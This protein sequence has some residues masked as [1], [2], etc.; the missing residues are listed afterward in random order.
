MESKRIEIAPYA[1]YTLAAG[2]LTLSWVALELCVD[3]KPERPRYAPRSITAA[4]VP[5]R[6]APRMVATAREAGYRPSLA[7]LLPQTS[8][9]VE[10]TPGPVRVPLPLHAQASEL[11]ALAPARP[12]WTARDAQPWRLFGADTLGAIRRGGAAIGRA[13]NEAARRIDLRPLVDRLARLQPPAEPEII[14]SPAGLT[15]PIR[16][17]PGDRL[18]MVNDSARH[19][20]PKLTIRQRDSLDGLLDDIRL[21]DQA[22]SPDSLLRSELTALLDLPDCEAWAREALRQLDLL[23]TGAEPAADGY[24]AGADAFAR[25]AERG[26]A[27]AEHFR[28]A[29]ARVELRKAAYAVLRRA[30]TW[31]IAAQLKERDA[32]V[33]TA[34]ADKSNQELRRRLRRFAAQVGASHEGDGWRRYLKLMQLERALDAPRADNGQA[35]R[36]LAREILARLAADSLDDQQR[37]F[38]STGV[39]AALTDELHLAAVDHVDVPRLV[40]DLELY[41][42]KPNPELAER[43]ATR[44][45]LLR[46]SAAE[47]HQQL[48]SQIEQNYRN[49]NVR[50][51]LAAHLLQRLL[52]QPQ[53]EA[54]PVAERIAGTPVRG[55]A[56]TST[57]IRLR[58]T[59]DPR[60]WRITLEAR[61]AVTARTVA[62]GGP[63][64]LSTHGDTA[65]VA[66][67]PLVI[68]RRGVETYAADCFAESQSQLLG[69]RTNFDG[70]PLVSS[71]V[72]SRAQEEFRRNQGR[73]RWETES[74]VGARVSGELDEQADAFVAKLQ[75]RYERAVLARA[76]SLRLEV[77][78]IE[79]RTTEQRLIARLRFANNRQLASH[80]PRNRAPADSLFSMQLHESMLNNALDGM[81]LGRGTLTPEEL[82]AVVAERLS[83]DLPA[84]EPQDR[85]VEFDFAAE[86][87]A[88]V[89]LGDG[90]IELVLAFDRLRVD[91][92]RFQDFIVHA[93]FHPRATIDGV[94]LDQAD[95]VQIEGR[96]RSG[97]RAQ[98]HAVFGKIM[99]PGRTLAVAASTPEQRRTLAGLMVT[100]LLIDDGW[101]GVA[102]GPEAPQRTAVTNRYLK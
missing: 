61:G 74:R 18:A 95:P 16:V 26:L 17:A 73:A 97:R 69:I 43:I 29:R 71:L 21:E 41:E 24:A 94:W 89:A 58:L 87:P 4:A 55:S 78:P 75:Q 67:K 39:V 46:R 57:D 52:P 12:L 102:L 91:N 99:P 98:L 100:Q 63:A 86:Q 8:N 101:L 76:E 9:Y 62:D 5:C 37:T 48:A 32:L 10:A 80:T 60:A 68:H 45:N 70:V 83:V 6:P 33:A 28:S 36:D 85:V 40:N 42:L 23:T 50:V 64:Q 3:S 77:E 35:R 22:S 65:F 38:T 53:P 88:R 11:V 27:E 54:Q 30:P 34:D 72:R 31:R 59:P 2:A 1:L 49:A 14:R 19:A 66:Q 47:G 51:A 90:H 79:V 44:R 84:G 25:H 92:A 82:R 56:L 13:H 81:D 15:G 93:Y 7:A 20:R 96:M